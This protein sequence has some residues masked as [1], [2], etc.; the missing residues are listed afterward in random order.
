MFQSD[1]EDDMSVTDSEEGEDMDLEEDMVADEE[2]PVSDGE[3]G[4]Y[5]TSVIFVGL[6]LFGF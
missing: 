6:H 1:S 2:V 3:P 4:N 5:L